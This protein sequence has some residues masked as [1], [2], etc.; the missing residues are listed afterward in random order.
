MERRAD[1]HVKLLEYLKLTIAA[2]H[3]KMVTLDLTLSIGI[4]ATF[5]ASSVINNYVS[6]G[7]FNIIYDYGLS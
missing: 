1:E 6:S 5:V 4:Q 2:T 7:N 3:F